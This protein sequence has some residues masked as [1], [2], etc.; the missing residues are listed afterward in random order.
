MSQSAAG[1]TRLKKTGPP[2]ARWLTI[3]TSVERAPRA[4]DMPGFVYL[5]NRLGHLQTYSTKLDRPGQYAGWLGRGYDPL[6]TAF[7]KR[8]D[9][10]NP[11]FRDCTDA[12]LDFR[13]GGLALNEG[14][15]LDRL[16]ER[17]ALV[18]QFDAA[19]RA[20]DRS[21]ARPHTTSSAKGRCRWSL[22]KRCAARW[23]S[24]KNRLPCATV[25][26]AICLANR[27]SLR[28]DWSKPAPVS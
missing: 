11:F 1:S 15:T 21:R 26:G 7:R 8:G 12:D 9:N 28:G 18:D 17:R 4:R 6:A 14:L 22:R 10:D 24:D 13:I 27:R 19:R 25:T 20:A 23:T 2:T 5:P 16:R 3:S